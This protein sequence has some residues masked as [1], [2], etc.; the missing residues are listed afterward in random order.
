[1]DPSDQRYRTSGRVARTVYS[2]VILA[3]I[4]YALYFFGRP[5]LVL[6]GVG[7]VIA[8]VQTI[9]LPYA[10]R[11]RLV[12]V[13]PGQV[14]YPGALLATVDRP[15][16]AEALRVLNA[17]LTQAAQE[18]EQTEEKLQVER[19]MR[20]ALQNRVDE[21]DD[22][23]EKTAT[24]PDAVDLLTRA[25]LQREYSQALERWKTNQAR[26]ERLP[27]LM[28]VL[29]NNRERLRRQR[30]EISTSWKNHQVLAN[31]AGTIGVSVVSEGESLQPGDPVVE[32]L[33]HGQRFVRWELPQRFLRIPQVGESVKV[34]AANTEVVGIVD[35]ILPLAQAQSDG[36][37]I[38]PR[39]VNISISE[40]GEELPLESSVTVRMGYF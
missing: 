22:A 38:T 25:G 32:I 26:I 1:M 34:I 7:H 17:A 39:L 6:E 20:T 31:Q 10:A 3:I 29:Q 2:L 11:V 14:V 5:F 23:L 27:E 37:N 33:D 24:R 19:A 21:L 13:E 35:R 18:L 40:A 30:A 15:G 12:H 16:Q 36:D 28:R 8:P 9:S 4:G